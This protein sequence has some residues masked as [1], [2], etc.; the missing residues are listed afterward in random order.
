MQSLQEIGYCSWSIHNSWFIIIGILVLL[1]CNM[2]A[3]GEQKEPSIFVL[4]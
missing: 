1:F 3:F 2:C 4:V